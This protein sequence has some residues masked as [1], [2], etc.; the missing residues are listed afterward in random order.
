MRRAITRL[1]EAPLSEMLLRRDVRAGDTIL[2][3]VEGGTI[4]ADTV[5]AASA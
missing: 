2:L 3:D 5:A 1:V 4:V